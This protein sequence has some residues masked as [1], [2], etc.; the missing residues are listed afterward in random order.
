MARVTVNRLWQQLFGV[1]LVK[2][3]EDF[4][5]MGERPVNQPLLD[6]LA[7]EFQES[8]WDT[9]HMLK[10]MVL[11]SAYRQSSHVTPKKLEKDPENRLVSRGPRFRMDGEMIRD[12]ALAASELLVG[13][14]GGPS[15]KIYQPPGVWEAVAMQESNTRAYMPDSG[16]ALYRRSLYTYWKRAA[17]HPALETL[18]T[19]SR[20][21][22]VVRRERTNTPLQALVVMND[23][24]LVEAAR[25]LAVHAIG[26][27]GVDPVA[28]LNYMSQRLLARPLKE[29][30]RK[31]LLSAVDN[32]SKIYA[33]K[34]EA[35]AELL[36]VGESP[37]SA[38]I[39]V[40]EQA[41]WTLV[42][43]AFFNLDEALNK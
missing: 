2:T 38:E 12:Q 41:A 24:Q 26:Q 21:S 17:P 32:F 11:S 22:C 3:S 33:Q 28:R 25:H 37:V 39:P 30:E 43:S 6:W 16:E 1:G 7:V 14:I 18:G 20:E 8:H 35:A 40:P 10:L 15:V 27:G 34:P 29:N 5:V 36:K 31:I 9:K 4:G 13:K 19:P 23:P 42:A